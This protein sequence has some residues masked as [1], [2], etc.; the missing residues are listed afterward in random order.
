MRDLDPPTD[1]ET[2]A[3]TATGALGDAMPPAIK[4][5]VDEV[6]VPQIHNLV[7]ERTVA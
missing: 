7:R 1:D 4:A 5:A 3:E 2:A 6:T